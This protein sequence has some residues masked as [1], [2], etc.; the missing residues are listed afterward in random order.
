[1][2]KPDREG[3][4]H[5]LPSARRMRELEPGP[6][7]YCYRHADG[8]GVRMMLAEGLVQDIT[9][10]VRLREHRQPFSLQMDLGAGHRMQ[11]NFF[12]PPFPAH[13]DAVHDSTRFLPLARTLLTTGVVAAGV[14]S[15]W[16]GSIRLETPHLAVRDRAPRTS[17]FRR[18]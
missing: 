15:L 6:V 2:L 1:V 12:H 3:F 9:V 5:T 13:R 4:S 17:Q 18:T 7:T 10:A 16:R 8:P 11:A 14:E